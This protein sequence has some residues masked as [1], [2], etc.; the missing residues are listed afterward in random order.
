V[1]AARHRR[2]GA[3]SGNETHISA[4]QCRG[5]IQLRI[6]RADLQRQ[7]NSNTSIVIMI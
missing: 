2:D 7:R 3:M 1:S 4:H 6:D 5:T